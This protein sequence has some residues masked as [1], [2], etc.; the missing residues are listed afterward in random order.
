MLV[1]DIDTPAF[2]PIFRYFYWHYF[3][4]LLRDITRFSRF[5]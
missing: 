4:S 1:D 2:M 5:D 3:I